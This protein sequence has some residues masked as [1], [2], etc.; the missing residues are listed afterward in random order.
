[1]PGIHGRL[2]K[3]AGVRREIGE[4]IEAEFERSRAAVLSL[5][6]QAELL[7]Q[8]P[9]LKRSIQVRNPYVDPL[10]LLQVALFRRLRSAPEGSEAESEARELIRLTIQGIA[11]GLRTTG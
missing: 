3:D 1:L 11:G 4:M 9:W 8:V 6:G 7:D 5:T 2:V 10:N